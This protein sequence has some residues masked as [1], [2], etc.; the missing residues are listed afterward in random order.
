VPE[1]LSMMTHGVH[2]FAPHVRAVRAA[3]VGTETLDGVLGWSDV[4]VIAT[5]AERVAERLRPGQRQIAYRHIP[6]P[7][8]VDR[9]AQSLLADDRTS[10]AAPTMRRRS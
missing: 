2:R 8:D 3:V 4:V 9:L 5:G 6:D 7:S 1:F 10:A